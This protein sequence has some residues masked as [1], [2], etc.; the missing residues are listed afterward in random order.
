VG[1]YAWR[2]VG[3]AGENREERTAHR[4]GMGEPKEIWVYCPPIAFKKVDGNADVD[5]QRESSKKRNLPSQEE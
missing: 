5:Q 4:G 2:F 3:G 1:D